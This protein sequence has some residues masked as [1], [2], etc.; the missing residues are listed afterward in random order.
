[1]N[2]TQP[3]T[4]SFKHEVMHSEGKTKLNKHYPEPAGKAASLNHLA[5]TGESIQAKTSTTPAV[6]YP[7]E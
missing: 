1:M 7:K 3:E 4:F 5:F 2:E 6:T